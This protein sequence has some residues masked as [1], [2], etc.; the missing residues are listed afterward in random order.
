MSA[1]AVNGVRVEDSWR[2]V[3]IGEQVSESVTDR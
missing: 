3:R 2:E 1:I